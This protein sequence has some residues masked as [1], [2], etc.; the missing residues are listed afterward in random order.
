M[1]SASLPDHLLCGLNVI[2]LGFQILDAIGIFSGSRPKPFGILS[3]G[4]RKSAF[5]ACQ[6]SS[7]LCPSPDF[8]FLPK[9][10]GGI[11]VRNG[12]VRRRDVAARLSIE[13]SFSCLALS[14]AFSKRASKGLF[15]LLIATAARHFSFTR[16]CV[17][18]RISRTPL[19]SVLQTIQERYITH[20][21]A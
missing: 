18:Q 8:R 6:Y 19:R 13:L 12:C 7:Q 15:L 21:T 10:H 9:E 14:S 20:S 3:G 17:L 16:S 1:R 5:S 11:P 4:T 2:F